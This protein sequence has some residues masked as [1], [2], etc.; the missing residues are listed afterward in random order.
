MPLSVCHCINLRP[1]RRTKA[2]AGTEGRDTIGGQDPNGE[3]I[4][5]APGACINR[6]E[7]G[8][9]KPTLTTSRLSIYDCG[10]VAVC[11]WVVCLLHAHC[12]LTVALP[13][14]T[15]A[16]PLAPAPRARR[17]PQSHPRSHRLPTC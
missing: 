17:K 11:G 2:K 3:T 6:L 15:R 10:G 5:S 14:A 7:R 8:K 16:V 9:S 1:Y 13:V 12:V 4:K